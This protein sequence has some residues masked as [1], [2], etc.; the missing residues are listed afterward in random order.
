VPLSVEKVYIP[1]GF[2][3]NDNVE[4]ALKGTFKSSC[5]KIGRNAAKVDHEAREIAISAT[6][7]EYDGVCADALVPFLD[8]VKVG[9]L[10]DG[11]Y[12]VLVNQ[13]NQVSA[14]VE[15]ARRTTE[16]PDDY[17]YAPVASAEIKQDRGTKRQ[18][19]HLEGQYPFLFVGCM[20][21]REVRV[22]KGPSEIL[23]VQPITDIIDTAECEDRQG[24]QDYELNVPMEQAFQGDGLLHVRV[25][26]GASLNKLISFP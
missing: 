13:N 17:L 1:Q 19:L 11:P 23:V 20:K 5:F 6:A 26:N 10:K 12:K 2:D 4:I 25:L 16:A 3:D 24:N 8:V 22:V 9:V 15:I 21:I 7:I 18:A 14:K